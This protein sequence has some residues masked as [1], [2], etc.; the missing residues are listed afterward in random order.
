[1]VNLPLSNLRKHSQAKF[2]YKGNGNLNLCKH[3]LCMKKE[4]T[5]TKTNYKLY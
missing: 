3:K 4:A 5:E 1:M 2:N